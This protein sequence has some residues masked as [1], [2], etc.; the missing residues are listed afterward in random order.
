MTHLQ[1]IRRAL[2]AAAFAA[3]TLTACGTPNLPSSNPAAPQPPVAGQPGQPTQPQPPAAQPTPPSAP[4][5][6]L[7]HTKIASVVGSG[8][9]A[10]AGQLAELAVR[11]VVS[12]SQGQGR[13]VTTGTVTFGTSGNTIGRSATPTDRLRVVLGAGVGSN[14]T[15]LEFKFATIQAADF[16]RF[17]DGAHSLEF[18][19]LDP[20]NRLTVRS[21]RT[22]AF[23]TLGVTGLVKFENTL[24]NLALA[25]KS[26]RASDF[27][28]NPVTGEA[29]LDATF[30]DEITG[31]V[32]NKVASVTLHEASEFRA[33]GSTSIVTQQKRFFDNAW[34]ENGAAFKL[35]GRI[36][37]VFRDGRPTEADFWRATG[38]LTRNGVRIGGLGQAFTGNVLEFF[39]DTPQGR[40]SFGANAF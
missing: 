36:Q 7:V 39:L 3:L 11:A 37:Q 6:S 40:I 22:G 28:S 1:T 25:S 12:A 27:G 13:V 10:Q 2:T 32:E 38:D 24:F 17:F 15:T 34:T 23:R 33:V 4:A 19:L 18:E 9:V 14:G 21:S 29:S 8:T 16:S 5:F 20:N 35:Q 30:L 26:G 31:F